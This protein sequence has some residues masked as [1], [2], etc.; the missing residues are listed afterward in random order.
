MSA[1]AQEPDPPDILPSDIADGL[2]RLDEEELRAAIDFAQK[3]RRHIHPDVTE[4]IEPA[5]GEEIVRIEEQSAYTLV[6]KRQPC[7]KSCSECP[8]G[9][10]LY[11]V[12][13]VPRPDGETK[14]HWTYLGSDQS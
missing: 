11:H 2:S 8:H 5:P 10:F 13:E 14:L 4:Q 3:R 12:R 1:E 6:S 9:P 7:A